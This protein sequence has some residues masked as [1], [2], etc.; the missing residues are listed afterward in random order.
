VPARTKKVGAKGKEEKT[1]EEG[2]AYDGPVIISG[3]MYSLCEDAKEKR[4]DK[5]RPKRENGVP[6]CDFPCAVDPSRCFARP[7]SPQPPNRTTKFK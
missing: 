7:K 4:D 3:L 1:A 6:A 5:T 2:V